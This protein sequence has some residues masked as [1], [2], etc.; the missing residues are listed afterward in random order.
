MLNGRKHWRF[1]KKVGALMWR[2]IEPLGRRFMPVKRPLQAL[3]FGLVWGWLPCGLVYST[4]A[5][6]LTSCSAWQGGL[7]MLA[8]GLGTLPMVLTL[9]MTVPWLKRIAH[10][11]IIRKIVGTIVIG[12]GILVLMR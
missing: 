12:F 1:W 11:R 3:G 6:S 4:L 5:F 10:Q 2:R 9:G 8:F 7:L